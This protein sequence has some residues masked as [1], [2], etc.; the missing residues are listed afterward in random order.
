MNVKI[1]IRDEQIL[2][3]LLVIQKVD[4]TALVKM[5]C[6]KNSF[7][8]HRPPSFVR[9]VQP[10]HFRLKL[11]KASHDRRMQHIPRKISKA[12]PELQRHDQHGDTRRLPG[13]RPWSR[14]QHDTAKGRSRP[15]GDNVSRHA[16]FVNGRSIQVDLRWNG[17]VPAKMTH[18]QRR[19]FCTICQPSRSF[20]SVRDRTIKMLSE[21]RR[22]VPWGSQSMS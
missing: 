18:F 1:K 19:Q 5:N 15:T 8:P 10:A 21:W 16:A 9:R 2:D 13:R 7:A 12:M 22:R 14:R 3:I 17:L 11:G 4:R 6:R 20:S